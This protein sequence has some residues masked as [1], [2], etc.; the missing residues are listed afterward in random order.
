MIDPD[1]AAA[2]AARLLEQA[3]AETDRGLVELYV[4]IA[5]TWTTLAGIAAEH[6][7]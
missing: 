4:R 2:N 5:E 7:V 6:T 1:T 3:E